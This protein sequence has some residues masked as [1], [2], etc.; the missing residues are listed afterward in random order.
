[1]HTLRSIFS[2]FRAPVTTVKP[3]ALWKTALHG[4]ASGAVVLGC[5][6]GNVN[7]AHAQCINLVQNGSFETPGSGTFNPAQNWYDLL[8]EGTTDFSCPG[9]PCPDGTSTNMLMETFG[10]SA[11]GFLKQ[12]TLHT[13]VT[14]SN[15]DELTLTFDYYNVGG[16][17]YERGPTYEAELTVYLMK[18]DVGGP[19]VDKD[20]GHNDHIVQQVFVHNF[21]TGGS[22]QN[23]SVA[24]QANDDYD[25][26]WFE[27][28]YG[29]LV[30][31]NQ[32][33]MDNVRL[34]K[35][36]T[37]YCLSSFSPKVGEN[38][39][40][41]AWVSEDNPV[42]KTVMDDGN[43]SITFLDASQTA[44]GTAG[45]FLASGE[46]IDGWQKIEQFFVVP[47]GTV[48]IRVN[49][50]NTSGSGVAAYFDDIRISPFDGN[51]V[52]YV[53]DPVTLRLMAEL[54]EN[55]YATVYEYDEEGRLIRTKKETERG[56]VTIQEARTH[57]H[58]P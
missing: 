36:A 44:I 13:P 6:A 8:P 20:I 40:L 31:Y 47:T 42:G 1:M 49:L 21:T 35:D 5:M 29:G 28:N 53:Y 3:N 45:P 41:S 38:Y 32:G 19:P 33:Y 23:F 10:L 34:C 2:A 15:G 51:L 30:N 14:V 9:G 54:D 58:R 17:I 46:V 55:N 48:F 50:N 27:I 43:V 22:W 24:F 25:Y 52:S 18:V 4:L 37:Q 7:S 16:T 57:V 11:N 26:L 56:K 39:L 12:P